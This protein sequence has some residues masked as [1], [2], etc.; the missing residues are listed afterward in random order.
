M[1]VH[2]TTIQTYRSLMRVLPWN[3]GGNR[4]WY[5]P[6]TTAARFHQILELLI[7]RKLAYLAITFFK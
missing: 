3:G 7:P 5:V 6:Q 2:R 4:T 1:S